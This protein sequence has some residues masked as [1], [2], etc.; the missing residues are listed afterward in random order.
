MSPQPYSCANDDAVLFRTLSSLSEAQAS[1]LEAALPG[2]AGTWCLER[3]ESCEGSLS[4]LLMLAGGN[5]ESAHFTI[6]QDVAGLNL[7]MLRGDE[8]TSC[9]R[10]DGMEA[11]IPALRHLA[12][13][14]AASM[15]DARRHS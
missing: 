8:F 1:L 14:E 9:G 6:D 15:Q 11:L 2:L 7:G 10:Y 5:D 3:H 12:S 13:L 4:L